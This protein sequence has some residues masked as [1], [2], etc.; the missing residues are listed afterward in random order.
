MGENAEFS[1]VTFFPLCLLMHKESGPINNRSRE[2]SHN[3]MNLRSVKRR[4]ER[5]PLG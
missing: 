5:T 4:D 1:G 3:R 2:E